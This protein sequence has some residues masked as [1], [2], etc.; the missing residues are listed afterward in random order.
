[1]FSLV[2]IS[3][4]C[5]K[6]EYVLCDMHIKQTVTTTIIMTVVRVA[7]RD[8]VV[9]AAVPEHHHNHNLFIEAGLYACALH[10]VRFISRSMVCSL[11][12]FCPSSNL[13][14]HL[15]LNHPRTDLLRLSG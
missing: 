3:I 1:M 14:C 11:L 15:A 5:L 8:V 2:P 10:R 13:F 6:S 4:Q 12:I 7:T 9:A